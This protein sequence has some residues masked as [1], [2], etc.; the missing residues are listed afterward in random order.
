M[1]G[2]HPDRSCCPPRKVRLGLNLFDR[3]R[4]QPY[5]YCDQVAFEISKFE[6]QKVDAVHTF[7]G[8]GGVYAYTIEL[9]T[10]RS[11]HLPALYVEEGS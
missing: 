8:P 9:P 11:Y 4:G 10:R 7:E 2:H 3:L 5:W 1:S 6:G